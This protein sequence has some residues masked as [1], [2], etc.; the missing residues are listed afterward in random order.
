MPSVCTSYG[1]TNTSSKQEC[2]N[3]GVSFHRFPLKNASLLKQW[4]LNMKRTDDFVPNKYSKICSEHFEQDCF[5][6]ARDTGNFKIK[7]IKKLFI[8]HSWF[9][10]CMKC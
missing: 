6:L 3:R 1:C 7:Y 2:Q 9:I 4:L 5:H 8:I 10:N